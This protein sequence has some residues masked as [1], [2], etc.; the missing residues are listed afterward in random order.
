[1]ETNP[2]SMYEDEPQIG[3]TADQLRAIS[4]LTA[5]QLR[6]EDELAQAEEV[7]KKL[8]KDL[9]KVQMVDLPDAMAA[10]GCTAFVT[11]DGNGITIKKD[12]SASVPEA[13]RAEVC[14]WL[15]AHDFGDL[16]SEDVTVSFGKGREADALELVSELAARNLIP[17]RKTA[18]NTASLKA[19]IREQL[20]AGIDMPL[21]LLG[22]Y[23]WK[24]AQI[25]RPK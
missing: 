10:A 7:V 12:I 13:K 2:T 16:V 3:P 4:D 23:E 11:G 19:L 21:D 18:V 5:K 17:V 15:R 25:A 20:A 24:K 22:A 9:D 6:L 8:K 1:M 14:A